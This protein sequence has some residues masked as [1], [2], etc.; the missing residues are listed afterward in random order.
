MLPVIEKSLEEVADELRDWIDG[1]E[2][3]VL[4]DW[5]LRYG[6]YFETGDLSRVVTMD[7]NKEKDHLFKY[8]KFEYGGDSFTVQELLG[9]EVETS[10]I[11][12]A[13]TDYKEKLSN[14][15]AEKKLVEYLKGKTGEG[16]IDISLVEGLDFID[17]RSKNPREIKK[18]LDMIYG[19]IY[20][21]KLNK[22]DIGAIE[23]YQGSSYSS[24]NRYLRGLQD[25]II[26][27]YKET[28]DILEK[29]I[30]KVKIEEDMILAR[31]TSTSWFK[32]KKWED[33]RVGDVIVEDGFMS[34]SVRERTAKGFARGK[35]S[36][37]VLAE[38]K[39]KRGTNGV[40]IDTAVDDAWESE[41]IFK[42]GTEFVVE[43]KW[44]ENG[45]KRLKG[46]IRGGQ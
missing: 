8:A 10:D 7:F 34:A 19:H 21:E 18:E 5:Y 29:T 43:E 16:I 20:M 39:V 42:P 31:G 44:I 38:I 13:I 15:E 46:V 4:D 6:E 28:I 23:T 17:R 37:G 1:E 26:D 27:R 24:I 12:Y 36:R 33:L 3:P 11:W 41:F 32:D 14:K 9:M 45:I 22:G 40:F 25:D 30:E 2:N 35:G